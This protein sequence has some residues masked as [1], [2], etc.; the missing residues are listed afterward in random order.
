MVGFFKMNTKDW[1][2]KHKDI[3]W[4]N[5]AKLNKSVQSYFFR[6]DNYQE[7]K[8]TKNEFIKKSVFGLISDLE[9]EKQIKWWFNTCTGAYCPLYG[10]SNK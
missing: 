7:Y 1:L 3:D 4:D 10:Y 8:T 6:Y 9:I 5:E 2:K